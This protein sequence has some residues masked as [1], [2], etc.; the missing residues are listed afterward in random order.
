MRVFLLRILIGWWI[1][2]MFWFIY[3]LL[4][5]LLFNEVGRGIEEAKE[6]ANVLWYGE[7]R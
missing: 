5:W 4:Y 2:P 6:F 1:I 3:P 7:I